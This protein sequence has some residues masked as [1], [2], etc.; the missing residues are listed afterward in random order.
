MKIISILISGLMSGL[1]F[2]STTASADESIA[3]SAFTSAVENREPV[4]KVG[5]L[6][7]DKEKIY[8]FTEIKGLK[9]RTVTHRWEHGGDVKAEVSF[10]VGSDRWRVWSS[11]NLQPQWVGEWIVTV[12]DDKG[13]TLTEESMAYVPTEKMTSMPDA[14]EESKPV[15]T[16]EMP[17]A[18]EEIPATEKMTN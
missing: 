2:V 18:T 6:T 17:A 1:F 16:E 9:G 14:A 5:Q 15:M 8:F 11:K 4:D 3:R 10:K 7:N 13:N 12:M